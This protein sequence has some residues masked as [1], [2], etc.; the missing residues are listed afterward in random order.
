MSRVHAVVMNASRPGAAR[1]HYLDTLRVLAVLMVFLYHSTM[2]FTLGD[3]DI[4]N[5]ERSLP[6]SIVF[7]AFLAPWGMPF[8]FL[9]AGA[10]TWFALE[11]RATRQY[12]AERFRRLIVPFLVGSLLLTPL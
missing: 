5:A 7:S 1:L 4:A 10:A 9:L 11:R 3:P 12:V 6:A 2:P 8:F